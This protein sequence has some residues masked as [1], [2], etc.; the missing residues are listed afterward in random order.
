MSFGCNPGRCDST[1]VNA[2]RL[3]QCSTERR[4]V[5]STGIQSGLAEYCSSGHSLPFGHERKQAQV[6]KCVDENTRVISKDSTVDISLVYWK[7]HGGRSGRHERVMQLH[8]KVWLHLKQNHG[9]SQQRMVSTEQEQEPVRGSSNT[10]PCSCGILVNSAGRH[11]PDGKKVVFSFP[12]TM[13]SNRK[14][15]ISSP[16]GV[17]RQSQIILL[18]VFSCT[19]YEA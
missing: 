11:R 3:L 7:E 4:M 18:V 10:T 1:L 12:S 6:S 2:Q 8:V 9:N 15:V 17:R 13:P 5:K 14:D 19:N 16:D